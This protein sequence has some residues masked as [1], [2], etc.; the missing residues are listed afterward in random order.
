M[1]AFTLIGIYDSAPM[2]R[3]VYRSVLTPPESDHP[4]PA[5][6]GGMPLRLV[7]KL[8]LAQHVLR[9][10]Y[11]PVHRVGFRLRPICARL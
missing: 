4:L 7:Y 9:D 5:D 10:V 2:M 6:F 3:G 11:C 1:V 8:R